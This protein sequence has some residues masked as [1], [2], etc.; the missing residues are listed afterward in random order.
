MS[1]TASP[2]GSKCSTCPVDDCFGKNTSDDIP[3]AGGR[4]VLASLGLF[5][6]PL[7]PALIGAV[8]AG[9]TPVG[10]LCGALVGLGLGMVGAVGIA[11][12]LRRVSKD[13]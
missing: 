10:Q 7:V 2:D 5:L 6:G 13:I 1:R 4:F 9:E 11:G 12:I 8:W 3:L